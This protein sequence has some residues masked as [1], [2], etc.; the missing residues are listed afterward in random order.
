M[1][2]K[3]Q[4][5]RETRKGI[6]SFLGWSDIPDLDSANTASDNNP[7]S[8]PKAATPGKVSVQIPT[9]DWLCKKIAKLNLTLVEGYSS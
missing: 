3:E 2:S 9:E 1:P 8:G 7:F 4:T 6:R 5:Y